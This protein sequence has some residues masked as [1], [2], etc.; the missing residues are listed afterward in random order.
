MKEKILKVGD[1][2][3]WRGGFGENPPMK[4]VVTEIN[5]DCRGDKYGGAKEIENG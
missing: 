5:K 4:A 3:L 1:T 2:V